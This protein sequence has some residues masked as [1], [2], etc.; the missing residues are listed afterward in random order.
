[1]QRVTGQEADDRKELYKAREMVA[2]SCDCKLEYRG[3]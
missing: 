1:M 2:L 3:N